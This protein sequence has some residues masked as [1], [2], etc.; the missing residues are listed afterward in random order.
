MPDINKRSSLTNKSFSQARQTIGGSTVVG[1]FPRQSKVKG[2]I[3]A[4]AAGTWREKMAKKVLHRQLSFHWKVLSWILVLF[5]NWRNLSKVVRVWFTF[6]FK[7]SFVSGV[8]LGVTLKSQQ[9]LH[10]IVSPSQ[11]YAHVTLKLQS[12]HACVTPRLPH[13][14]NLLSH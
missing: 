3:L 10:I 8:T 11:K 14:L 6:Q 13:G 7:K 1:N 4:S 2:L 5:E 12:C 9:Q